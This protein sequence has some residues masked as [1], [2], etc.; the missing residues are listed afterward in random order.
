MTLYELTQEERALE[1][2][3]YENGGELTEEL[4]AWLK[5]NEEDLTAKLDGYKK[6]M[7]E[8]DALV[9]ATE[10]E[11]KKMLERAQKAKRAK[12][13]LREHILWVMQSSNMT[14]LESKGG[15]KVAR[16][17]KKNL[18]VDDE[19]I[20]DTLKVEERIKSLDLPEYIQLV[21]KVVKSAIDTQNLPEGCTYEEKEYVTIR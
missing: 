5:A 3:L 12:E 17:V 13:R 21:P 14:K 9:A 19:V 2:A 8:Y 20:F 6:I 4:D 1:E 7:A 10:V 18:A 16:A 11:M 15:V